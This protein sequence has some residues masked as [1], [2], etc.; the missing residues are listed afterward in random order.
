VGISKNSLGLN[1]TTRITADLGLI[2][3]KESFLR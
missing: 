2:L 1:L 3:Q